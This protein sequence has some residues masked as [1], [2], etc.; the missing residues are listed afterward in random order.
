MDDV[1]ISV[2]AM[3]VSIGL[4]IVGLATLMFRR[5]DAQDSRLDRLDSRIDRLDSRIDRIDGRI[6]QLVK[7]FADS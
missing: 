3:G 4:L 7:A 2:I 1:V 6:D 5:F